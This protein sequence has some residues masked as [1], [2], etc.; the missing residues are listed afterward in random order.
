MT[1]VPRHGT[2]ARRA[3]G[4]PAGR[5]VLR[6]LTTALL[7]AVALPAS[8]QADTVATYE[9]EAFRIANDAR[10]AVVADA[11]AS[12]GRAL[13]FSRP[14]SASRSVTLRAATD[15]IVVRARGVQC[16]GGPRMAVTVDGS[17][18]GRVTL[19]G[20][21]YVEHTF[22]TG[23][24]GGGR[25][26]KIAFEDGHASSSCRRRLVVDQV[27]FVVTKP[28]APAPAPA[29][30]PS[31]APSPAPTPSPTP[32]PSPS[33]APSPTPAPS[34]SP[35]PSPTP[36]P[37]PSPTRRPP[38]RRRPPPRHRRRPGSLRGQAQVGAAG[39]VE[40]DHG[41]G[42][43]DGAQPDVQ[44]R[45][46][47]HPRPS[48][49]AGDRPHRHRRRPPHPDRRRQARRRDDVQRHHRHRGPRPSRQPLRRGRRHGLLPA[50]GPR[51]HRRRRQQP[52]GDEPGRL[53]LSR[54]VRPERAAARLEVLGRRDASGRDPEAGPDGPAVH[55]QA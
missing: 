15:A 31:P 28:P 16:A 8:A 25:N 5:R 52:R 33:P 45:P 55:R 51:R 19:A 6:S 30:A 47:R 9:T 7:A 26:V 27:R 22:T 38:H 41:Q 46:G 23:F 20:T 21:G 13:Q 49:R 1:T 37:A 29:P 3:A 54:P 12:G 43:D 14:T 36:T 34:P 39:P 35:T 4:A 10:A 50:V 40:P 44:R 17:V 42:A 2:R 24:A 48:R 53:D 11:A 18:V 32:A